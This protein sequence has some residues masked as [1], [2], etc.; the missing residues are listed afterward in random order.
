MESKH[1]SRE[2]IDHQFNLAYEKLKRELEGFE[3][4]FEDDEANLRIVQ[5]MKHDLKSLKFFRNAK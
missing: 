2:E 5:E 1:F 3:V 4:E